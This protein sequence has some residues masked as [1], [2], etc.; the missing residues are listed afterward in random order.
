L[1]ISI[2]A[3]FG[4]AH[5]KTKTMTKNLSASGP[6]SNAMSETQNQVSVS[7]GVSNKQMSNHARTPRFD[8]L[9]GLHSFLGIVCLA[10]LGLGF[11]LLET[12]DWLP[13]LSIGVASCAGGAATSGLSAYN[14]K[15]GGV[16]RSLLF[17]LPVLLV[18]LVAR[19]GLAPSIG[20]PLNVW[21]AFGVLMFVASYVGGVVGAVYGQKRHPKTTAQPKNPIPSKQ[22][23]FL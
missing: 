19:I 12:L 9:L 1:R 8:S 3:T 14:S 15:R 18:G 13:F 16:M 11:L 7:R 23:F 10:L 2:A 22:H 5:A 20:L 17:A 4:I 21:C 6:N